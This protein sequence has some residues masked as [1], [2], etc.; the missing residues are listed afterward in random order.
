[1][2][3][4]RAQSR[5]RTIVTGGPPAAISCSCPWLLRRMKADFQVNGGLRPTTVAWMYAA[6]ASHAALYMRALLRRKWGV[7]LP[8]PV[9]AGAGTIIA[10]A[11]TALATASMD[12]FSGAAHISGVRQG[13]FV[14][15]G[16]YRFTRNPQYLGYLVTLLGLAVARRSSEGLAL[17]VAAAAVFG[18][19]VPVEE[20]HLTATLGRTYREYVAA[21]PRW[22]GRPAR[23]PVSVSL[24]LDI[25]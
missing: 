13:Q 2:R 24:R 22:I 14:T 4:D 23:L 19:W 6:Y 9:V 8:G 1:M 25:D 17:T 15:T 21:T 16:P 5:L 12:R 7:P 3:P 18:Y 11:G 20:R 10:L